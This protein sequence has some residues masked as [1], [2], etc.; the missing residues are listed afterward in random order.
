M[1]RKPITVCYPITDVRFTGGALAT[2]IKGPKGK[3]GF[4]VDVAVRVAETFACDTTT[5][6]VRLG[7]TADPDRYA[8]LIIP[9]GTA[10]TNFYN[11]ADDRDALK[12]AELPEETQVE[13]TFVNSVDS[14]VAAG[15]GDVYILVDWY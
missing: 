7:T 8:E 6:K 11:S 5:A 9:D 13:V 10:A 3:R 15:K 12:D 14:G 2:S 4:L 1:H